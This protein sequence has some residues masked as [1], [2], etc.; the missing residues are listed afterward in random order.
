[1]KLIELHWNEG[2][3]EGVIKFA[4][5]FDEIDLLTKLDMLKDCISGLQDEYNS[6]LTKP[7]KEKK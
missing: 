4:K 7:V 6:M 5:G 1:M 2:L 3:G